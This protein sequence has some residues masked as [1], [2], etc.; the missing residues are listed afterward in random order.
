M[1]LKKYDGIIR[2]TLLG[3]ALFIG[4]N[5][6]AAEPAEDEKFNLLPKETVNKDP[7]DDHIRRAEAL[8]E[9]AQKAIDLKKEK[10]K[11]SPQL[12]QK[13]ILPILDK[14]DID[15]M[16]AMVLVIPVM[17]ADQEDPENGLQILLDGSKQALKQSQE[18]KKDELRG[19]R[20]VPK[21]EPP[22]DLPKVK[23]LGNGKIAILKP[24]YQT[25]TK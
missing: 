14:H 5:A 4:Q 8:I 24:Q 23:K 11:L 1:N 2:S 17:M 21:K 18:M 16:G 25:Q 3:I 10:G 20:P 9:I 15:R 19:K 22:K 13:E 12:L 7:A 6:L